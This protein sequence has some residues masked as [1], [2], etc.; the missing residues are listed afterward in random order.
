MVG[1]V[2]LCLQEAG[3]S[4]S[5]LD[6]ICFTKGPGMAGETINKDR[7]KILYYLI[8]FF[9]YSFRSIE[10]MCYL[11]SNAVC[12]MENTFNWSESLHWFKREICM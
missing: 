12:V 8:L 7:E 4:E 10:I 2:K 6:V 9:H 11:C 5:D 1:L 3:V